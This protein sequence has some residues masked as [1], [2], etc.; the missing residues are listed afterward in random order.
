MNMGVL[1]ALLISLVAAPAA[2][3]A[4]SSATERLQTFQAQ[5][6][7]SSAAH[8]WRSNLA[9]A[10]EMELFLNQSPDSILEVAQAELGI[11]DLGAAL[12]ELNRYADM[13]QSIDVQTI[14]PDF[15]RVEKSSGFAKVQLAMEKNRSPLSTGSIAFSLPDSGLLAEDIDYDP[16]SQ[17]FLITSVREK[18]I[19]S[20]DAHGNIREFARTPDNW[21]MLAI[22][23]DAVRGVVW[24]TEVA[25]QGF[26]FS[27]QADWGR[28]AVLCYDLKSGK[29]LRRIEGPHRSGLGDMAL[30][31]HGDVIVSDGDSGGV[32]RVA[33]NSKTLER[34]DAG[35]FISPQTPALYPDGKQIFVP[36]YVRGIGVLEIATKQV[37]W[38][39]MERKFALTGIDGL[40]FSH[41]RLI[42][43]QN[44]T[45]PERIAIF[46][47]DASHTR[48]ESE[49]IIER[50]M[51]TL[52]P[53]H[54]V[55]IGGNFY[56]IA[57]SGWNAIDDHGNIKPGT[58]PSQ[59]RIIR[60]TIFRSGGLRTRSP[61][62]EMNGK[63]EKEL[64]ANETIRK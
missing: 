11:G 41:G 1:V 54:G 13:G 63:H 45:S 62:T 24:A 43:V 3:Q 14:S 6:Q 25:M 29:L 21:P 9:T 38:L 18:K 30:T 37:R 31:Q 27:P 7:K 4:E 42:A 28:S 15:S 2:K 19:V 61:A 48:I 33:V 16:R 59:S 57:N 17:R 10:K 5:L 23:V 26:R 47:L 39:S 50:S 55:I 49:R 36:D 8:D 32:Y 40:Y 44:G 35:D 60:V 22:K 12:Y 56:Y 20:A 34:I 58:K 51:D 53:T 46:T 64:A 52:D